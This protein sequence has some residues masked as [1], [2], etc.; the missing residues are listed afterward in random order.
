MASVEDFS[1]LKLALDRRLIDFKL[2]RLG[3]MVV[4]VG[5]RGRSWDRIGWP[6]GNRNQQEWM[7]WFWFWCG[8]RRYDKRMCNRQ[9]NRARQRKAEAAAAVRCCLFVD[10]LEGSQSWQR[11]GARW[12]NECDGRRYEKDQGKFDM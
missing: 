5:S 12:E 3:A 7:D 1:V 6:R 8:G 11:R 9:R 10:D 2:K 4:T